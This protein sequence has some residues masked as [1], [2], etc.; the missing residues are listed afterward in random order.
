[1]A[2]SEYMRSEVSISF[3]PNVTWISRGRMILKVQRT[4]AKKAKELEVNEFA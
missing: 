3:A 2:T 1:M 4:R